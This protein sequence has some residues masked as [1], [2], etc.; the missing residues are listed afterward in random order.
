MLQ[1]SSSIIVLLIWIIFRFLPDFYVT[2]K[3]HAL[4]VQFA[5]N[6]TVCLKFNDLSLLPVYI[7]NFL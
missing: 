2:D 1:F 6:H 7:D 4:F 5:D 3:K